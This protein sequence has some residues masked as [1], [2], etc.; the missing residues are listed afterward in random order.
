MF[1]ESC[2]TSLATGAKFCASCG[3]PTQASRTSSSGPVVAPGGLAEGTSQSRPG[4]SPTRLPLRLLAVLALIGAS[5]AVGYVAVRNLTARNGQTATSPSSTSNKPDVAASVPPPPVDAPP[6]K[7]PAPPVSTP[8]PTPTAPTPSL[9]VAMALASAG[10]TAAG[11]GDVTADAPPPPGCRGAD[12]MTSW[13]N[14]EGRDPD[15][16]GF[17]V[18]MS[19]LRRLPALDVTGQIA[20]YMLGFFCSSSR[21]DLLLSTFVNI[22]PMPN[23]IPRRILGS[24][25]SGPD[26]AKNPGLVLAYRVDD[27]N[28]TTLWAAR[29]GNVDG[30]TLVIDTIDKADK[31]QSSDG[32]LLHTAFPK[33][34]LSLQGLFGNAATGTEERVQFQFDDLDAPG[35]STNADMFKNLCWP[36]PA[37]G[38]N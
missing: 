7:P 1:C 19:Q 34:R 9:P 13:H 16:G 18:H 28:M 23:I 5:G 21:V 17:Q 31:A 38:K 11:A 3:Q 15:T 4:E 32:H 36:G 10:N 26:S 37:G 35:S 25:L 27:E 33:H 8:P 20:V 29:D 24:S 6:Y 14:H 12:C 22:P 30:N 2:G